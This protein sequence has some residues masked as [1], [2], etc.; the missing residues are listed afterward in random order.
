MKIGD[1]K[2]RCG[3]C[4][5]IDHCDEPYSDIAICCES[6]FADVDEN[7]FLTVINKSKKKSKKARI[8]DVAKSLQK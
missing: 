6:R 7:E 1:L 5:I 2:M 3:E 8:N 4:S